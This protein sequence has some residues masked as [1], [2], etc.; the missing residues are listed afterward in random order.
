MNPG[1]GSRE[2]VIGGQECLTV[3]AAEGDGASIAGGGVAIG[4]VRSN[5]E[6]F[7]DSSAQVMDNIINRVDPQDTTISEL[8]QRLDLLEQHNEKLEQLIQRL[9]EHEGLHRRSESGDSGVGAGYFLQ[10][11]SCMLDAPG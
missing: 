11:A 1:I 8:C 7:E 2:G 3:S 5:G 6:R 10:M 4:I 9:E